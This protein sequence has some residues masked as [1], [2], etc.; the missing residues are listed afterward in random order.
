MKRLMALFVALILL[1]MAGCDVKESTSDVSATVSNGETSSTDSKQPGSYQLSLDAFLGDTV[2]RE[3]GR[4]NVLEGKSY[5]TEREYGE[6]YPDDGTKL[7]DGIRADSFDKYNWVGYTGGAVQTVSFDLGEVVTGITDIDIRSFRNVPYGIGLPSSVSVYAAGEDEEYILVGTLQT[8]TDLLDVQT[9]DYIFRFAREVDAR[10]LR[11]DFSKQ[12]FGWFFLGE[13]SAYVYDE[14]YTETPDTVDDYYGDPFSGS[15][16]NTSWD[17]NSE[18]YTETDNLALGKKVYIDSFSPIPADNADETNNSPLED[19]GVLTDGRNSGVAGWTAEGIFR[20]TRGE[21]RTVIIDLEHI[22]GISSAGGSLVSFKSW[23]IFLPEAVIVS[24]SENGRDWQGMGKYDIDYE[25]YGQEATALVFEVDFGCVIAA[26]YVKF[27]FRTPT[28]AAATEFTVT[29]TKQVTDT[30]LKVDPSAGLYDRYA[31][32]Y[33]GRTNIL[34]TAMGSGEPGKFDFDYAMNTVEDYLPYV[35]YMEGDTIVD[36]FMDGFVISPTSAYV[37]EEYRRTLVGWKHYIEAQFL[38]GYNLDALDEAVG[39]TAEALGLDGY[40]GGILLSILQPFATLEDG[41]ANSFGDIDGDG[42]DDPLTDAANR[43][44][45]VKWMIDTQLARFE[46]SGLENLEI[47]GFYWQEESIIGTG[48]EA[49]DLLDY[50][51]EY[52]DGLGYDLLWIPYYDAKGFTDWREYGIA[53]ACLQP[54][55]AFT[56]TD[57]TRLEACATQAKLYGMCVEI[58][59]DD[60]LNSAAVVKYKQ[61]L[62]YGVKLGSMDALKVY[63]LGALPGELITAL[64]SPYEA[65]R[66]IYRD[67]YLFAKKRLGDDYNQGQAVVSGTLEASYDVRGIICSGNFTMSGTEDEYRIVQTVSPVYG[68]LRIDRDGSFMYTAPRRFVGTDSFTVVADFGYGVSEEYTVV[69]E[70][71]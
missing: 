6:A 66:A 57:T 2:T 35:A 17:S 47:I 39:M 62:E 49:G 13:I 63:Y 15:D 64:E 53:T 32:D 43:R 3:G 61:Y 21:G 8:P 18:S 50:T 28:H 67:T 1:F 16:D 23:G 51:V 69:I 58:E 48:E 27:A 41:T 55:Y 5:T 68:S 7:T 33:H 30:A 34:C 26:R 70:I 36:T 37:T 22:S 59:C 9:Y 24:V 45:A 20:F 60:V 71:D 65:T 38:E 12:E 46:A 44:M 4:R 29:G 52:L 42:V 19:A 10:Y 40:K 31:T 54:N 56:T 11:F 25:S 14:D